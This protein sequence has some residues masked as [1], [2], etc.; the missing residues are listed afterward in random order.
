MHW[1]I[2]FCNRDA[3]HQLLVFGQTTIHYSLAI[4]SLLGLG[5]EIEA[6]TVSGKDAVILAAEQLEQFSALE[7]D[8]RETEVEVE[9]LMTQF[10]EA[11]MKYNLDG[12]LF[13][14]EFALELQYSIDTKGCSSLHEYIT[15]YW[16]QSG[17]VTN[18]DEVMAKLRLKTEVTST[19]QHAADTNEML[20]L[21]VNYTN[22]DGHQVMP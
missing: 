5:C 16:E 3:M 1:A 21:L 18:Y 15:K 11:K 6:R 19:A 14:D 8:H 12:P 4:H 22:P 9:Q 13:P 17:H 10:Q 2:M 20:Q 7:G